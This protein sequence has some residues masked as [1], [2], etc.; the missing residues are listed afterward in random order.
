MFPGPIARFVAPSFLVLCLADV[1]AARDISVDAISPEVP[2]KIANAN[3]MVV[4]PSFRVGITGAALG[5]LPG[6]DFL[7]ISYGADQSF[8][9]DAPTPPNETMVQFSVTRVSVG[10]VGS[11]VAIE[12]AGNGAAGDVFKV[13][14]V[15]G[16]LGAPSKYSDTGWSGLTPLPAQ[17]A[18]DGLDRNSNHIRGDGTFVFP[19]YFTVDAA[20]AGRLGVAQSDI[21][22]V[23]KS[24]GLFP[25]VFYATTAAFGLVPGDVID[26]LAIRDQGIIGTFDAPDRVY[27]TLAQGSPS[28]GLGGFSPAD[29]LTTLVGGPPAMAIAHAA[30]GLLA[31]DHIDAL[32]ISDPRDADPVQS[33]IGPGTFNLYGTDGFCSVFNPASTVTVRNALGAP[34]DLGTPVFIDYSGC[35][36]LLL[37]S[38]EWCSPVSSFCPEKRMSTFT[39]PVGQAQWVVTGSVGNRAAASP[40]EWAEIRAGFPRDFVIGEVPVAAYDQDGVNGVRA[41]DLSLF[42]GD[43]LSN[44]FFSRSDYDANGIMTAGDLAAWFTTYFSDFSSVTATRCDGQPTTSGP[45]ITAGTCALGW[46]DCRG[47]GGTKL[48]TFSCATNTGNRSLIA[49][50]TPS[51]AIPNITGIEASIDVIGNVGEALP[52]WW[53][54]D[55]GACRVNAVVPSAVIGANTCTDPWLGLATVGV[56]FDPPA[57]VGAINQGRLR[58]VAAVA[59]ASAATFAAGNETFTFQITITNTKTTGGGACAGCSKPVALVMRSIRLTRPAGI[60]DITIDMGPAGGPHIAFWQSTPSGFVVGVGPEVHASG[61]W[62]DVPDSNPTTG[63]VDIRYGLPSAARGLLAIYDV[64]GRRMRTLAEGD[65]TEG[66][67]RIVWDGR[68][69]DGGMM[70]NGVYFLRLVSGERTASRTLVRLR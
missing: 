41:N 6:E 67:H 37:S 38:G 4:D 43:I 2:A 54:F 46:S 53:R 31:A 15:G 16:V 26:A 19:V 69:D 27:F 58:V 50:V 64:S 22:F 21:L 25:L 12:V 55:T 23:T 39:N 68:R 28:L 47:A 3:L 20:A 48:R 63:P 65:Q 70:A 52:D 9:P 33:T 18:I 17:S 61:I 42:M 14:T 7:G 45:V 57:V 60:G 66:E 36:D 5:L 35:P 59:P 10:M 56:H 49:S 32:T 51:A 30:L 24:G 29:I 34:V 13:S 62:L 44:T 11:P 40:P 8:P 1:A